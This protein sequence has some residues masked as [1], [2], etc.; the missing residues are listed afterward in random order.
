VLDQLLAAKDQEA[1][2]AAINGVA[3]MVGAFMPTAG[4]TPPPTAP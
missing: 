3:S 2:N 4:P 1:F